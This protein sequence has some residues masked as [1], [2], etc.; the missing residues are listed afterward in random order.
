[1]RPKIGIRRMYLSFT[2]LVIASLACNIGSG[3]APTEEPEVI[4]LVVTATT[5]APIE[6]T[7]ATAILNQ[8]LNVRDGPG[9][10]YGIQ[11]P[12]PGGT[13]VEIIGKSETE[14]LWWLISYDGVSGWVSAPFT[15]SSNTEDVPVVSVPAP[16]A[17]SGGGNGDSSDSSSSNGGSSGGGGGSGGSSG[18]GS[19]GGGG[20]ASAPSD[21]TIIKSVSIKNGNI[22]A[23]SAVSYPDGDTEDRVV[24][25]PTGFDSSKKSGNLSFSLTCSGGT[26]KVTYNGGSVTNGSAGC[27]KGWTVFFTNVSADG[28]LKIY[29]ESPG[30]VDWQLTV[31]AQ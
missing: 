8:D 14:P 7:G 2:L 22:S 23:S 29:L 21:S 11:K 12:L 28:N 13:E 15:T 30:Y 5:E 17:S 24:I 10:A 27:N 3:P 31:N 1:M 4:T 16:Q 6:E 18:G 26:A 20:G 9:T 19:G 25:K